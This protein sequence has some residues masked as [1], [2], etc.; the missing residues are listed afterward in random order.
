MV[1]PDFRLGVKIRQFHTCTLKICNITLTYG[2]I[3]KIPIHYIGIW[4]KEHDGDVR[5][6]T[7]SRNKAVSC[8]IPASYRHLGWRNMMANINDHKFFGLL[9]QG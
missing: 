7:G 8:K 1:T 2:R 6:Q 3:A 4:V 5:F 9:E